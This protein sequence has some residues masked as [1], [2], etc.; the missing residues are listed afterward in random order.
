MREIGLGCPLGSARVRQA[1]GR[2]SPRGATGRGRP[3]ETASRDRSAAAV[4]PE[5][6]GAAAAR[7]TSTRPRPVG[8]STFET[9]FLYTIAMKDKNTARAPISIRSIY[10]AHL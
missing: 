9:P 7:E 1:E 10:I 5:D 4:D 6:P 2:S 3:R 8:C